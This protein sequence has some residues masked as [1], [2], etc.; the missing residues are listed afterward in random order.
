ME[1][2]HE[3]LPIY[4]YLLQAIES[5]QSGC[6]KATQIPQYLHRA[7]KKIGTT[8]TRGI[9][10]VMPSVTTRVGCENRGPAW[11]LAY[12]TPD[13]K[14]DHT[15]NVLIKY[16][17]DGILVREILD[18]EA[19]LEGYGVVM[20]DEANERT[21]STDILLGK[22]KKAAESDKPHEEVGRRLGE[23]SSGRTLEIHVTQLRLTQQPGDIL[24][25]LP[26]Q[27]EIEAVDQMLRQLRKAR[28]HGKLIICHIIHAQ[29]LEP[30]PQGAREIRQHQKYKGVTN[31]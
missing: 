2:L 26:G 30:T 8:L 3:R 13:N 14:T 23:P 17:T 20:V 15:S 31:D 12:S 29:A 16:M 18:G 5:H 4:Q 21:L 9:A 1:K 24:V 28:G 19:D 6:G 25:F 27:Q 11:I 7:G 10:T 22:L